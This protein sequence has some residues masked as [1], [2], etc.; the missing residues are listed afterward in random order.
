MI[1]EGGVYLDTSIANIEQTKD[2]VN[3]SFPK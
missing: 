1:I 3:I 2:M